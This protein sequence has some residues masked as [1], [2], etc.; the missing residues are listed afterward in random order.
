M[1]FLRFIFFSRRISLRV[2]EPLELVSFGGVSGTAF[3]GVRSPSR[4]GRRT[5][6]MLTLMF[7]FE[8]GLT[9]LSYIELKG[10]A[11]R[12]LS[13]PLPDGPAPSVASPVM[14]AD[15]RVRLKVPIGM[16]SQ[17]LRSCKCW[18]VSA[19]LDV[20][21]NVGSNGSGSRK[22]ESKTSSRS[23]GSAVGRSDAT[24]ANRSSEGGSWMVPGAGELRDIAR[25]RSSACRNYI[26]G[27]SYT[28]T[29]KKRTYFTHAT[30]CSPRIRP[31]PVLARTRIRRWDV[32][33]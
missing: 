7:D 18:R 26:L 14:V 23:M 25:P 4:M 5:G 27:S 21:D 28:S 3:V 19:S 32:Q 10:L 2:F 20:L 9:R 30:Q 17:R 6:E 24:C 8:R 13:F 15:S 29:S 31:V 1:K 16:R 12:R 11:L 22:D 33:R